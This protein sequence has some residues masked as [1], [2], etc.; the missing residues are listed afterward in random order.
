VSSLAILKTGKGRRS[1][2]V[3]AAEH[4]AMLANADGD[5]L[6]VEIGAQRREAEMLEAAK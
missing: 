5:H 6:R 4:R 3:C 1:L 2:G